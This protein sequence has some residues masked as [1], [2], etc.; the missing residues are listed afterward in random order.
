MKNV[1]ISTV[2]TSLQGNLLRAD[3][4]KISDVLVKKNIKALALSL[5]AFEP[6]DRICGAEINSITSILKK[7]LLNKCDHL[8]LLVSETEDGVLVG[9]ILEAY[10]GRRQN[11]NG[12]EHVKKH[13][14]QGLSDASPHLFRT[15]GLRNLVKIIAEIVKR[16]GSQATLINATGGYK[17]Q[18]SFAGMIGQAL[19][20][21]V[22]YL[23]ERFSDVI[24]LPPQPISLDLR[25][26]LDNVVLFFDLAQDDGKRNPVEKDERFSS[27]VDEIGENGEKIIGLSPT[28][29]LFHETFQY[30]FFQQKKALLPPNSG[31]VSTDKVIKYEDKNA[32]KHSGLKSYL[33]K[34][35]QVPYIIRIFTY[36]YNPDLPMKKYF[37]PSRK[38]NTSQ[39][40]GVYSDG[41]ATTKFD[42]VTTAKN[43]MER[44]AAIVDLFRFV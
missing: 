40:E 11:P 29:Q 17:A 25:F 26:W 21:P 1:L 39:I 41:K 34:V 43:E 22:C 24:T 6:E 7:G 44:N 4:E 20:I 15:E 23:F 38:G 35:R 5:S 18:I 14:I 27:L 31:L 36:Y 28:G 33:E 2:G 12:F 16:H 30:R 13:V 37:R 42:L 9:D 32:A 8:Y 10:Y 3:D 19:E